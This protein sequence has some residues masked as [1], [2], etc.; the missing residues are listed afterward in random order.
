MQRFCDI[1][2]RNRPVLSLHHRPSLL[3]PED[4]VHWVRRM[5]SARVTSITARNI[6]DVDNHALA[7][8]IDGLTV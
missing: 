8:A 3:P 6:P 5:G 4:Y 2:G 1:T 7:R